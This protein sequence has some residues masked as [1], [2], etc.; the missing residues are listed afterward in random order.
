MTTAP[1]GR[2]AEDIRAFD[3]GPLIVGRVP[4]ECG[5]VWVFAPHRSNVPGM[6]FVIK[7]IRRELCEA[8]HG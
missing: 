6:P 3:Y 5:C 7:F 8:R 1:R 4:A 2:P